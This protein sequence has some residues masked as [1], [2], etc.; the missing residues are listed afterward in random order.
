MSLHLKRDMEYLKKEVL[1]LGDRVETAINN[2]MLILTERRKDL[3]DNI[4]AAE[5]TINE[6]EVNIEEN[7]L[8]IL[9]LHQP[10]AVDLRFIVVV[11]KVNNDLERMG[12]LAVNV[13][14][15]AMFLSNQS[16]IDWPSD[17]ADVMPKSINTMVHDSL[18]ALVELD[19]DLAHKVIAMDSVVDDINRRMYSQM[20]ALM[21]RDNASI[22]RAIALLS[23]SRYLERVADLATNIAEDVIFMVEGEVI[24]HQEL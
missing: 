9:A 18:N 11:L 4:F 23:S 21:E 22:E 6:K 5:D 7:C 1:Q 20:Q 13:A 19:V 3:A 24:R 16:P 17:F 8:K 12:D 15:R 2:A 14:Q 10:V